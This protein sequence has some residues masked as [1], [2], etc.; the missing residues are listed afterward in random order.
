MMTLVL[1][2]ERIA[3][4][5]NQIAEQM[6]GISN[7]RKLIVALEAEGQPARPE[8]ALLREL[9]K[10]FEGTLAQL[11]QKPGDAASDAPRGRGVSE[12]KTAL[13]MK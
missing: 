1:T 12:G 10:T 2:S 8:R 4:G 7:Q 9:L 11:R 5:R 13:L 3:L 6:K